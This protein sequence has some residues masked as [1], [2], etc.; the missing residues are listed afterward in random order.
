MPDLPAICEGRIDIVRHE[1]SKHLLPMSYFFRNCWRIC[2]P[3]MIEETKNKQQQKKGTWNVG[4]GCSNTGVKCWQSL[5]D[6][7]GGRFCTQHSRQKQELPDLLP[8]TQARTRHSVISVAVH[9][10]MD[11]Q[12]QLRFSVNAGRY[13]V[14]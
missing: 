3:K 14:P 5:K 11:S 8:K 6:E 13:V 2:T 7:A 12:D 1:L 10:R 4:S 9:G